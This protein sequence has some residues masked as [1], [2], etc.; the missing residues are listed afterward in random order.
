MT[1]RARLRRWLYRRGL[2]QLARNN[3]WATKGKLS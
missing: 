2:R 1:W 3:Q